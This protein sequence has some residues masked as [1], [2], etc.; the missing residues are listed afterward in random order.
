[1]ILLH[2]SHLVTYSYKYKTVTCLFYSIYTSLPSLW[3]Y[4]S[5]FTAIIYPVTPKVS[6]TQWSPQLHP[7][8]CHNRVQQGGV[9]GCGCLRRGVWL[10]WAGRL[11]RAGGEPG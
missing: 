6:L 3:L 7:T 1:M 11:A 4:N 9:W 10:R 5:L 8:D 2:L